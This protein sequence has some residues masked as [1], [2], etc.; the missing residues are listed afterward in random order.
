MKTSR[1]YPNVHLFREEN[2]CLIVLGAGTLVEVY[3]GIEWNFAQPSLTNYFKEIV[4]VPVKCHQE[5]LKL[6]SHF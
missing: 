3:N 5:G 6:C 2:G 1:Y 4:S